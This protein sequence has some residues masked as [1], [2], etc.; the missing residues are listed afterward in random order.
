VE[1]L[2]KFLE[3]HDLPRRA[4]ACYQCGSCAGGC[5]VGRWRWDFNPRR[6]IEM[7]LRRRLEEIVKERTIWLCAYCLTCLEHCPQKIEVSEI[8]VQ[9]KN[10]AA[11]MGHA[12]ESEA[13]KG[14]LIMGQGWTDVPAKRALKKREEMGL[15]NPAP[16]IDP[17]ELAALGRIL[18]WP[19]KTARFQ[20]GGPADKEAGSGGKEME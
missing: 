3:E 17:D 15:P 6:F 5:P 2:K 10:A 16:G 11:R 19:A 14:G 9:L 12:P 13:K 18:D 8:M 4:Q 7:I 20:S 1:V